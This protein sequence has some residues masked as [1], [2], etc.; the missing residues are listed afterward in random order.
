MLVEIGSIK[1]IERIRKEAGNIES[2]AEDIKAN[3]LINPITLMRLDEGGYQLLAGLRRIKACQHLKHKVI[4]ANVVEAKDAEEALNIEY[5][6]NVQ[7][8]DF[9]VS[10][11]LDYARLIEEIEKTK[12]KDRM[13][14]ALKHKGST[15]TVARPE[16]QSGE[17]REI[18]AKKSGFGSGKTYERAK[19]IAKHGGSEVL[20]RIDDKETSVYAAYN[21]IRK[22]KKPVKKQ[23][24]KKSQKETY[25]AKLTDEDLLKNQLYLDLKEKLRQAEIEANLAKTAQAEAERN[26]KLQISHLKAHIM[27]LEK[28]I[29]ELEEEKR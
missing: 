20:S 17:A 12:A 9:T 8:E 16:R 2:L 10:E 5:S 19:Y 3:G 28:R 15:A 21:K 24:I 25:I 22:E 7:R 18:V 14:E 27:G 4:D 11:K 23:N 26:C 1:I 6:E 13:L 29:S